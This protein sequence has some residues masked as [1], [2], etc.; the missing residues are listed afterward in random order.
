MSLNRDNNNFFAI[1]TKSFALVKTIIIMALIVFMSC[2]DKNNILIT[3]KSEIKKNDDYE[4]KLT[5]DPDLVYLNS[6]TKVTANVTRLKKLENFSTSKTVTANNDNYDLSLKIDPDTVYT[7]TDA[8]LTATVT[9][10][11]NHH[12]FATEKTVTANN[13][14][15]ALSLKI[16]P[17]TVYTGTDAKLTAT[18]TR[19]KNHHIFATAKT[20]TANNDKFSFSLKIEAD[21]VYTGKDAIVTATLTRLADHSS[22]SSYYD[23]DAKFETTDGATI[24]LVNAASTTGTKKQT[25]DMEP[26]STDSGATFSTTVIYSMP[27]LNF[28]A[29]S[30]IIAELDGMRIELPV[31]NVY[32]P[33][34]A[35]NVEATGG[36]T[37]DIVL[38]SSYSNIP[39][40]LDDKSGSTFS[41]IVKYSMSASNFT[42]NSYVYLAFDGMR[43]ELPITNVKSPNMSMA[44]EVTGGATIDLI[45]NY[46]STSLPVKLGDNSG[47]TFSGT[48]IYK[49]ETS[50]F[51]SNNFLYADFD[52]MRI[53][54]PI[55]N[56]LTTSMKL[57]MQAV[58]GDLDGQ[59]FTSAS[60]ISVS[61]GA[62]SSSTFQA[63]AFFIPKSS[64]S[65]SNGYYNY[66][67]NGHV[68][69][70]FDGINVTLPIKMVV[71]R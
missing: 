50:S 64:Y 11:K 44:M 65:T 43:I 56:K 31:T 3:E 34:M 66:K 57:N 32:R 55:V 54:L 8:N 47:A 69:A 68:S 10:R 63:I 26:E 24:S 7:G 16:D 12:I 28:N 37:L 71:P 6:S 9:R 22:L 40:K 27:S 67:E 13:D 36:A 59:N 39:V 29:S 62:N 42:P 5:I 33:N 60:N 18:V 35:M 41:G 49:M 53:E 38:N 25:V 2:D 20:V 58:G 52:G 45:M 1:F 51:N 21:T 19:R 15:Y 46:S 17:D 4:L 61:L 48:A 14:N 70:S 23:Y 30:Y